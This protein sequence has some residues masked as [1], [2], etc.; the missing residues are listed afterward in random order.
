MGGNDHV[1]VGM[2][3]DQL[4]AR[5]LGS[6]SDNEFVGVPPAINRTNRSCLSRPM[7]VTTTVPMI[8]SVSTQ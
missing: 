5:V 6:V 8:H 1:T 7:L 4:P 3:R 2:Q